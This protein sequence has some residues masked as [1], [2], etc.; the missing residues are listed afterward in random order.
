MSE[1][2]EA[3]AE[4]DSARALFGISVTAELVGT[5]VQNLRAYERRGLLEP[6]RTPGGTRLYSQDDLTRLRRI[7]TLLA[8]GLNLAGVE[9]VL[10]LEAEN[11]VLRARLD[12][13][14]RRGA[15]G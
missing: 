14:Q 10:A 2:S 8:S 15:R 6:R 7:T 3:Y 5:G 1:M 4:S 9:A 13:A 12:R 11:A